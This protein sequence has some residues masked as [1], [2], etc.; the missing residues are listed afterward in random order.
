MNCLQISLNKTFFHLFQIQVLL[1]GLLRDAHGR[2]MSK[3]LGNV[4][5]P[6]DVISGITLEVSALREEFKFYCF[7]GG[8]GTVCLDQGTFL[9]KFE[10]IVEFNHKKNQIFFS[11]I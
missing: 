7:W 9:M 5:D 8:R 2:K 3:S 11:F 6:L 4:I 10:L 1:H